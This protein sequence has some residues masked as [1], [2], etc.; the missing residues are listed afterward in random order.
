MTS[1]S[2][3]NSAAVLPLNFRAPSE[4]NIY[5]FDFSAIIGCF[6]MVLYTLGAWLSQ[7]R[8]FD[9]HEFVHLHAAWNVF[10]GWLPYRDFF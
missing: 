8:A 9:Q 3:D 6:A 2:H 1:E 4:Y 10:N 7:R 5:G